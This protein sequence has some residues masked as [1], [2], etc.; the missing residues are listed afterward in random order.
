MA[1]RRK[2]LR[3]KTITEL[4]PQIFDDIVNV[5]LEAG[6]YMEKR[7]TVTL[8]KTIE[9]GVPCPTSSSYPLFVAELR[10]YISV[11]DMENAEE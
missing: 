7:Y 9:S 1:E 8:K 6:W 5:E 10:K 2:I 11:E 3:I 4:N